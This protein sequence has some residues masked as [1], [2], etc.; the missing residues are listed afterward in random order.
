MSKYEVG[1][2][3][4][5]TYCKKNNRLDLLEEWDYEKN[6]FN[7]NE[8]C[9]GTARKVWW[10][11]KCGHSWQASLNKRT[12]D[13]TSCPYCTESH[14]KLL[15]GFNDLETTNPELLPFWDYEKNG[16]LLPSMVMKGQHRKVWW[17]GDCGHSWQATIYHRV[18][19]R[20]CPI[21]RRETQTSFPEQAIFYYVKQAFPDAENSNFIVLEGKELDVYIPS[22]RIAVEFDGGKWHN[23]IK[24]DE[25]KNKLCEE[26]GITLV[27]IRDRECPILIERKNV[28]NIYF[29]RYTDDEL[30]NCLKQLFVKLNVLIKIDIEKDRSQIHNQFLKKRKEKSLAELSPN[31]LGE[32]N[33]EKNG[34]V[35]PELVT[36]MSAKK[37]W[38]KCSKGHEWQAVVNSRVKGHGCPYCN[39]NRLLEGFNDLSTTNPELVTLYDNA[40]NNISITEISPYQNISLYWKCS[41]GHSY[42]K[43]LRTMVNYKGDYDELC[44]YCFRTLNTSNK[45]QKRMSGWR[46]SIA[47]TLDKSNPEC[48]EEWDYELNTVSPVTITAGSDEKVWWKC[49]KGHSYQASPAN[50][51]TLKRGCPYCSGHK[52][53][54]GY[55]DIASRRPDLISEWNYVKNEDKKPS[56]VLAGGKTAYWWICKK[57]HEWQATFHTRNKGHGCPVCSGKTKKDVINLDTGVV[58]KSL[59]EAAKSCGLKVGDT[60]SFCCQGKLDTA[61]GYHWKYVEATNNETE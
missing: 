46:K 54:I 55:N 8:I 61:G 1:V 59:T 16:S 51:I 26:K 10:I 47:F 45:T 6:G 32:W 34:S 49:P 5:E 2:N 9:Y 15:S 29:D 50:H 23:S 56:E 22:Q 14:A 11:G 60:I 35:T 41:K 13:K 38:W 39:N 36:N 57:G 37:V 31:L 43:N 12:S 28:I 18:Q 4:L 42:K 25:L 30:T 3:D 24:K 52:I 17:K 27:R 44:P 53:L 33:Y 7:P 20:G 58:Y 21:C 19:G 40:K 48:L